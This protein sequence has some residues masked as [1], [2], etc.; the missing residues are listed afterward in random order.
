MRNRYCSRINQLS[1]CLL[2]LVALLSSPGWAGST[3]DPANGKAVFSK[4][5]CTACHYNG[6]N[7]L[8]PSKPIK[9]DAFTKKYPDDKSLENVI[10][11]GVKGTSMQAF[12]KEKV[13]DAEMKD[14]I[15]YIRSL[16]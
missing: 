4:A 13:T 3:G 9:G 11:T 14:L 10:R 15:A 5:T 2:C 16:K 8:N 1:L 6:G 7:S 12:G